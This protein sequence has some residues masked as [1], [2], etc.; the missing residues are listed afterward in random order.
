[1]R[2]AN[3]HAQTAPK[4]REK[5]LGELTVHPPGRTPTAS[6]VLA[7]AG[8]AGWYFGELGLCVVILLQIQNRIESIE[9]ICGNPATFGDMLCRLPPSG[10]RKLP[11]TVYMCGASTMRS[12]IGLCRTTLVVFCLL[13]CE[14]VAQT[15]TPDLSGL[16]SE[17]RRSIESACSHAKYMEGPA[18]YYQCL[19]TQL[20]TLSGPSLPGLTRVTSPAQQSNPEFRELKYFVGQW[21][22]RGEAK[23]SLLG[24][25][26]KLTATQHNELGS[27]GVSVVSDWEEERSGSKDSGQAVYQY[28]AASGTYTYHSVDASGETEDSVGTL[29]GSTWTW[30]SSMTLSDGTAVQGRFTIQKESISAYTLKFEI[31]PA[32]EA[33]AEVMEGRASKQK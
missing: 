12:R 29:S 30:L 17:D 3:S 24:P 4:R 22:I 28:D 27:D 9:L 1:M 8:G 5:I 15:P 6:E 19:R 20:D 2:I 33:W 32:N 7:S 31:M 25:A 18:A 13:P 14:L 16:S 26:G 23:A 11:R 21:T 10:S